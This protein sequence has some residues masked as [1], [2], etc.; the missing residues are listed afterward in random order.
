M[1]NPFVIVGGGLAA[2]KAVEALRESGYDGQLVVYCEERH[3]PYE[4]PPLSKDYLLGNAEIDT[5]FVHPSEWY[6]EHDV[7]LRLGCTVTAVDLGAHEV[8]AEGA[9]QAYDKLLIATGSSARRLPMADESGAP[10]AYLRTM[11]DSERIK[12]AFTPG[13]RIAIIGGGWIGLEVAS[14]ARA[15]GSEVTVLEA[16]DLPLVR[17]LGPEVAASFADLH[18]EHGV[19][20]RL[21]AKVS[22]VEEA[23]GRALVHLGDGSIVD[24]DLVLIGVGVSPNVELAETAGLKTDNGIVVDEHL[25]TSDPSVFAAGDVA[26]AQHPVLGRTLRVEHWDNAIEQGT[27]AGRNMAGEDVSYDR[28]PYFFTD[29]YDLG[30]EY[31]GNVGP[32]GYD[33]VVVRGDTTGTRV[34]TAFWLKDGRVLAGMHANDWDAIDAVRALVGKTVDV[35]RLRDE[36]VPLAELG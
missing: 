15:A 12:S 16:L 20:L 31:V 23:D 7:D 3:L 36:S 30:M 1:S 21:N 28:L 26:S 22:R 14:A 27:V 10:V 32:D 34:F 6:D 4:R 25:R 5:A 24:A 35:A 33:E 13:G 29:Q 9:Q 8:T 2:A 18:R 11:E 19:D 17:V